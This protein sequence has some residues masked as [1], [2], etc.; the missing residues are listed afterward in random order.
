MRIG[1]FE[2]NRRELAGA[3]GD[4][5]TLLPLAAGY[6]AVCGLDPSGFLVMMGLVNIALGLVYRLPMP[7][8]PKKVVA[9]VAIAE[10]WEPPLIY[11]TGW[12]L[13]LFWLMLALSGLV[14]W[15]VRWI[16]PAVV[17][18]I[19]LA[20]GLMLTIAGVKMM[21][22]WWVIGLIAVAIALLL[23]ENRHL[24]AAIALVLLGLIVIVVRGQAGEVFRF[25]FRLPPIT[26]PRVDLIIPGLLGAGLGQIPL[27]LTNATIATAALIRD[28]FPDKA[29]FERKLVLNQGVMNVVACF[30]GGM[31]MCHGA[32]G[33][34]GQYYFGART[35]GASILEGLIEIGLG[36]FLADSLLGLFNAFPEAILGAMMV[37]VAWQ[38][39]RPVT[40]L[41]GKEMGFALFTGILAAVTS[42]AVGAV[43][44]VI[45]YHLWQRLFER[46]SREGGE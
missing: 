3:M 42:M 19:Q 13:G 9:V 44:G 5:G 14:E 16:P 24:P 33:L 26:W 6:I 25:G 22:T 20:L 10:A 7:L 18:G 39:V 21:S 12:T 15:V 29:V 36:L 34:A 11:T 46:K 43:A 35:G 1:E 28:Y 8:E 2:F 40:R 27:T 37:L 45:G 32:Q 41:R 31:P 4:F 23:R 30:F 38:L 17:R